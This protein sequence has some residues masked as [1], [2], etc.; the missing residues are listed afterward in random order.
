MKMNK[1]M[2][3]FYEKLCYWL[4][5]RLVYRCLLRAYINAVTGKY[6]SS[7]VPEI[8]MREVID[9]WEENE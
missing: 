1:I 5:K 2:D 7:V 9:R 4:P 8:T 6:S 3:R